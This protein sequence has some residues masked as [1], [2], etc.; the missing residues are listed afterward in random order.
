MMRPPVT[1]VR[2]KGRLQT[3]YSRLAR[4]MGGETICTASELDIRP[5]TCDVARSVGL[6]HD[7]GL[8]LPC[9]VPK[10]AHRR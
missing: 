6:V 8:C 7:R 2:V 10:L 5:V 9:G 1:R 3:R 4:R